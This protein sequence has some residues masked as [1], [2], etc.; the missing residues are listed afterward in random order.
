[1]SNRD[2]LILTGDDVAAAVEGREREIIE[3]VGRAYLAHDAGDSSLPNSVFLR[4]PGDDRNRIIALPAYLGGDFD[5]AGVKWVSSFP[6]NL[7]RGLDRASAAI[8]LNSVETGRPEVFMEGSLVSAKR[9]AAGAALAARTLHTSGPVET[10]GLLGCGPIN[11]EVVRFMRAVAPALGRLHIFDV[12]TARARQFREKCRALGDFDAHVCAE[13]GDALRGA[14]VVSLA[15]TALKPHLF[16][17]SACAPGTT[18]LHVSL[19]DLAPEII[20]ACDNVV[21]DVEHVCRAQTSVHLAEQ[22]VGHRDFIRC[23]LAEA[24]AGTA[25]PAEG[26]A[27]VTVFSPFGLGV[28]DIAVARLAHESAVAAGRGTLVPSFFP[29]SYAGRRGPDA[30]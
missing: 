2:L 13:P 25:R 26:D 11:F 9:T 20:L 1:M 15:T 30:E 6:G 7:A 10:L 29:D 28:L 5:A 4:F 27:R 18:V 22:L 21:D 23:T 17:L 14:D 16:D 12:D 8:I 3:A 19:R 24:L